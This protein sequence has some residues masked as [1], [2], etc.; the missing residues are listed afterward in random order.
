MIT[1]ALTEL[2]KETYAAQQ[3]LAQYNVQNSATAGLSG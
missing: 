1:R 3:F 2:D